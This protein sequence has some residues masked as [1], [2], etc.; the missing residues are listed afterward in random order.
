MQS[1][2]PHIYVR[3]IDSARVQ[4][5]S[6]Y[7]SQYSDVSIPSLQYCPIAV[8]EIAKFKLDFRGLSIP[9]ILIKGEE[10]YNAEFAIEMTLRAASLSFHGVYSKGIAV[11][12]RFPANHVQFR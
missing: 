1:D 8:W 11:P 5:R 9:T 3:K 2:S 6:K 12:K 4:R 7:V 10:F